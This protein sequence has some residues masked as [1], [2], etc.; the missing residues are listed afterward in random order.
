MSR[1]N[2]LPHQR[3]SGRS[4]RHWPALGGSS[5]T[6]ARRKLHPYLIGTAVA[7]LADGKTDI[8]LQPHGGARRSC[9]PLTLITTK[10]ACR[11]VPTGRRFAPTPSS[12][13]L[14]PWEHALDPHSRCEPRTCS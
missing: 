4:T 12:D 1:V 13:L 10:G 2:R 14:S 7:L 6:T 9:W 11:S 8:V 5:C 3:Q